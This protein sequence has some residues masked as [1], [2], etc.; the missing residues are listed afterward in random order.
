M[1]KM[2][3]ISVLGLLIAMLASGMALAGEPGP[4][5]GAG[6]RLVGPTVSAIIGIINKSVS[7][8]IDI[9]FSGICNGQPF[10]ATA[11]DYFQTSY[12]DLEKITPDQLIG[13][14]LATA[15]FP[16]V[17]LNCNSKPGLEFMITAV[18][19][20][21]NYSTLPE[22]NRQIIADVTIMFVESTPNGK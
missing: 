13:W 11:P 3:R 20:F 22:P 8:G 7:G 15:N 17:A 4:G 10:K 18:N 16:Q 2:S 21:Y 19:K 14:R 9:S 6:E 12:V 5:A 1:K